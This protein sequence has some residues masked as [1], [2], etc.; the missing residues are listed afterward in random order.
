MTQAARAEAVS[1]RAIG[2]LFFAVFGAIWMRNGLAAMHRLTP[3]GIAAILT[4]LAVLVIPSLRLIRLASRNTPQTEPD[5]CEREINR[6]F[7]RV[8]MT[9]WLAIVAAIMLLN[10]VHKAEFLTPV[11]TFIVGMHLFPL[12]KLFNYAAHNVTGT[13]LVLWSTVVAATL[14]GSMMPS[15]CSVGTAAILLGSA[16]YTIYSATRVART[17]ATA[18]NFQVRSA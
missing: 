14:P 5:P 13:L 3:I 18:N 11:I 15:I 8:N 16:A 12:A 17:I 9:Q 2:V 1:G 7:L 10:L 6:A 4:I